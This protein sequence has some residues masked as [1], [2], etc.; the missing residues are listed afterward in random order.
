MSENQKG[1]ISHD[2]ILLSLLSLE[3]ESGL[4]TAGKVS[5]A[6]NHGG[7]FQAVRCKQSGPGL[8]HP[9]ALSRHFNNKANHIRLK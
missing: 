4:E 8:Y 7:D 9:D 5:R 3:Q 6:M 2:H 1:E